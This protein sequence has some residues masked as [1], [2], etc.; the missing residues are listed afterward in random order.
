MGLY[1]RGKC[2][3]M[4]YQSKASGGKQIRM[5]LKTTNKRE[6]ER[7][8]L[9]V[10]ADIERGK[11]K[12]DNPRKTRF[13]DFCKLFID[14][15]TVFKRSGWRD[16]LT[17]HRH[18]M[19]YFKN[20]HMS[21]ISQKMIAEYKALRA[22]E[23]KPATVNRELALLKTIFNKAIAWE[24]TERNP[25]KGV[26][27]FAEDNQIERILTEEEESQ[28]LNACVDRLEYLR[29]IIT[30][31][32]H[33]GMRRGELLSLKWTNVNLPFGQIVVEATSAKSKRRRPLPMN[34]AVRAVLEKLKVRAVSGYVFSRP[35]GKPYNKWTVYDDFEEV[36]QQ[37]GIE[38]LR[39]HD[40][41]HTFATRLSA[42]GVDIVTIKDLLGH[43]SIT[44]TMRYAHSHSHRQ[45]VELL[46]GTSDGHAQKIAQK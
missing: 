21:A 45:A 38:G 13:D 30:M 39:F 22:K 35:N 42:K 40:L 32:L 5:S 7:R 23:V 12:L 8:Y 29:S 16:E 25:V 41:R 31:A 33:T 3:W 20:Y 15:H 11:F 46:C 17:I 43:S 24:M 2:W 6:A 4:R 1:Q 10:C 9:T 26:E 27:L 36:R 28:L 37:A 14:K 34:T 18:L 44:T 19:P